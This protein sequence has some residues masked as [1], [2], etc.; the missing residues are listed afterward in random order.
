MTTTHQDLAAQADAHARDLE[1]FFI[2]EDVSAVKARKIAKTLRDLAAALEA[3]SQ[4]PGAVERE[5]LRRSRGYVL[6]ASMRYYDGTDGASMRRSAKSL[7][8]RI[9]TALSAPSPA[10]APVVQGEA[11]SEER[12]EEVAREDFNPHVDWSM[13][14]NLGVSA[15]QRAYF[16]RGF[17]KAEAHHGIGVKGAT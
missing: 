11:L 3:A 2:S 4:P 12:L 8:D 7:L 13:P 17:R 5:L 15:V 16:R 9:D 10:Q 14:E 6:D 1:G